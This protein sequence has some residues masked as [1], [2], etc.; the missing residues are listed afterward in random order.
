MTHHEDKNSGSGT[1]GIADTTKGKLN[2]ATGKVQNKLGQAAGDKEMEIKGKG[3]ELG[4]G[5]QAQ[6]G[7]AERRIEK[8]LERGRER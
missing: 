7:D 2:Q 6:G 8:N 3:R 5:V 4:G 1:Q